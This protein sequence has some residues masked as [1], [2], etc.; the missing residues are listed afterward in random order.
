[1]SYKDNKSDCNLLCLFNWVI[2]SPINKSNIIAKINTEKYKSIYLQI[3]I[4]GYTHIKLPEQRK[5]QTICFL[6]YQKICAKHQ[7]NI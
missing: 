3:T 6:S 7:G 1:M 5:N 2:Q 4:F